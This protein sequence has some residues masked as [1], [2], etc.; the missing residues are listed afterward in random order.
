MAI[1]HY[2]RLHPATVD[3][4]LIEV[5]AAVGKTVAVLTVT[6]DDGPLSGEQMHST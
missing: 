6:D 2:Y 1:G 5:G 3:F 4:A